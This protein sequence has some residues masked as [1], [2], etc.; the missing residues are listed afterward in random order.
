[1]VLCWAGPGS[2]PSRTMLMTHNPL[3]CTIRQLTT[4]DNRW[5]MILRFGKRNDE[6]ISPRAA[7]TI[8]PR[9]LDLVWCLFVTRFCLRTLQ[10]V[11]F[12]RQLKN[13]LSCAM[14]ISTQLPFRTSRWK[15]FFSFIIWNAGDGFWLLV[16]SSEQCAVP[17]RRGRI[18]FC[19]YRL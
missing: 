3:N 17:H 12:E 10:G 14:Q 4:T 2:V 8:S 19:N 13:I 6:D 9:H 18:I 11:S 16:A 5:E 1:M 7:T 15:I